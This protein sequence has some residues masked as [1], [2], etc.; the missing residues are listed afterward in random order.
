M[1]GESLRDCFLQS[2]TRRE[3]K[4]VITYLRQGKVDT[5]ISYGNLNRDSN[6]MA[7]SFLEMGLKKGDRVLLFLPK[8]LGFVIAHLALQKIGAIGVP[9]NPGFTKS[10]ISYL[11]T[12]TEA[13][14][15]LTGAEQES[16]IREVDR[17]VKILVIDTE[18]PYQELDFFRSSPDSIP[19]VEIAPEDPGLIIY[20]SGTTGKPKGAI[21]TQGNLIHDARNIIHIW[22]ITEADVVCHALP[23]FHVHGLCFELH[24][25]LM[26]GDHGVPLWG[27]GYPQRSRGA[28]RCALHPLC[29]HHLQ[30]LQPKK[31]LDHIHQ[32]PQ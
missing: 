10:E 24:T 6:Q 28:G 3:K 26:A 23:L 21:L 18:R 9:V 12:D 11:L 7:N 19:Q 4:R 29:H 32:G 8:S 27:M 15:V 5:E 22:E 1:G 25:A 20:T 2:F 17:Q 13:I 31:A 16:I 14:L 30:G